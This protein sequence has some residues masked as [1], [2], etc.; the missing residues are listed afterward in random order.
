[1][2]L[3]ARS[4]EVVAIFCTS[5]NFYGPVEILENER[6]SRRA[7]EERRSNF[8]QNKGK[9]KS[10]FKEVAVWWCRNLVEMK[11]EKK[12]LQQSNNRTAGKR[13]IKDI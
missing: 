13:K 4:F 9:G 5:Q 6:T 10:T 3:L 11:D 12:Y 7:R 2:H 1:M 8:T